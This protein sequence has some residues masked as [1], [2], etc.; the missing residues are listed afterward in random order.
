MFETILLCVILLVIVALVFD[1]TNGFHDAANSIAT[2]VATGT[3]TPNQAVVLA[4]F[5]NF[6][7]VFLLPLNIAATIGKGIV[8]PKIIDLYIIF[9]ALAGAISWNIITWYFG[10]PTSS[11]H[12]LIGGLLGSTIVAVG[13]DAIFYNGVLKIAA[14]ILISP[15]LGFI[16]AAGLNTI[17]RAL[18]KD[19][20]SKFEW[21]FKYLQIITSCFYSMGHGSNDAQK[22]AGIIFLILISG[23]YLSI[24]DSIPM[25]VIFS[26]FLVMGLG[27]LFGGWKIVK[28]LGYDLAPLTPRNGFCAEISGGT[29]LFTTSLLGIPV[30]TTHTITGAVLGVGSSE[31]NPNVNW[32]KAKTILIAWFLTIPCSALIAA[33][34][35]IAAHSFI[36]NI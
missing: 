29:M 35:W 1:F 15:L 4:A 32:K 26:S 19:G 30:S 2:V 3:L 13:F 27:T 24:Q 25:W 12:A 6:I 20:N 18:F 9:G 34:F 5:F 11:S 10:L 8:D 17:L 23:G 36:G 21:I 31:K 28:T 14:F 7:V 22:T 16:I 33:A